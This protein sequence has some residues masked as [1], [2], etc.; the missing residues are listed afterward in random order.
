MQLHAVACGRM[1]LHV[2]ACKS[3]QSH[4]VACKAIIKV[5]GPEK[6][7]DVVQAKLGSGA[8]ASAQ[9]PVAHALVQARP[10]ALAAPRTAR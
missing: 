3:M 4:A 8:A 2:V 10:H 7:V 9:L 6:V 5:A 1:Q